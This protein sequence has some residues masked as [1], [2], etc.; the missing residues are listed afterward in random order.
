MSRMKNLSDNRM[1]RL[2]DMLTYIRSDT[3]VQVKIASAILKNICNFEN[4]QLFVM[5]F[6]IC[7]Y[8]DSYILLQPFC[9]D[10]DRFLPAGHVMTSPSIAD[11]CNSLLQKHMYT[12]L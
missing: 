11:V 8:T 12:R 2:E 5:T 4:L 6:A 10:D 9:D 7:S 1:N 3:I